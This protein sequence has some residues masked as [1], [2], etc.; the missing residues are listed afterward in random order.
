MR[1][2]AV[3]A[4]S[5]PVVAGDDH[6]RRAPAAAPARAAHRVEDAAELHVLERD[7]PVVL[8]GDDARVV[9]LADERPR[10]RRVDRALA[11]EVVEVGVAVEARRE[12]IGHV[13]RIVR[14][15]EVHPQEVR[16]RVVERCEPRDRRVGRPVAAARLVLGLVEDVEP[17]LDARAALQH[18]RAHEAARRITRGARRH[19]EGLEAGRRDEAL[20]ALRR[21]GEHAVHERMARRQ[22][23]QVGRQRRRHGDDELV[24][25]D[26]L[27]RE[28]VEARRRRA[29]VAVGA[30]MV[31]ACRVEGDEDDVR[32][33]GGGVAG[34]RRRIAACDREGRGGDRAEGGARAGASGGGD[35]GAGTCGVH[36]RVAASECAGA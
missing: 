30:E 26:R 31:G 8:V 1:G 32:Q 29:E 25:H 3:L 18:G 34:R 10:R 14:V 21:V 19:R 16:L 20:A 11:D 12:R 4:Q 5:F 9:D 22:D 27:R 24:E 2:L 15:V 36:R 13:E 28:G 33:R 35:P 17:F 23:G 7:G 6:G